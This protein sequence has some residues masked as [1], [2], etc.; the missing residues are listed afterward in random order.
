MLSA[1][2]GPGFTLSPP[3]TQRGS[4][5]PLQAPLLSL[6]GAGLG[7]K[8]GEGGDPGSKGLVAPTWALR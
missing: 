4:L 8:V 6:W 7:T 3:H 1:N 5:T 2:M